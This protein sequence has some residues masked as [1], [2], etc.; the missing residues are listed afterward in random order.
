MQARIYL[1][2]RLV[3]TISTNYLN[4]FLVVHGS[5]FKRKAKDAEGSLDLLLHSFRFLLIFH[6]LVGN[7]LG[8]AQHGE[9]D[10]SCD[11]VLSLSPFVYGIALRYV[12]WRFI[13]AAPFF[14]FL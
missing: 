1:K 9:P 3:H 6:I 5:V 2:Y 11:V 12:K 14:S 4:N 7:L 10:Y 8:A 13:P